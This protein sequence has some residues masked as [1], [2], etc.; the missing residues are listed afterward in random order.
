MFKY[1]QFVLGLL[2]GSFCVVSTTGFAEDGLQ[3]I[4]AYLRPSLPITLNGQSIQLDNS[5]VMVDGSTYLRLRDVSKLT[6][7]GVNWNEKSQT[8]ELNTYNS[9][10]NNAAPT[11]TQTPTPDSPTNA[12]ND[13][14]EIKINAKVF[15]PLRY[16]ADKYKI[17]GHVNYDGTSKTITFDKSN[18]VVSVQSGKSESAEAFIDNSR[19]FL[20]EEIF[21][22]ASADFYSN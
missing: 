4:E 15:L 10:S 17:Y 13:I 1:K 8:V 21:K 22:K 6:G 18:V 16:G 2:V 11:Q 14:E 12:S 3:K 5:P 20:D 9:N 7:M 19:V